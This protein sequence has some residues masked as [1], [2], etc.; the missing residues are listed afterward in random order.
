MDTKQSM[1]VT[2]TGVAIS[3][4][5]VV[6]LGFLFFG[7][8]LFTPFTPEPAAALPVFGTENQSLMITDTVVG[9]GA[10]ATAGT[11]VSLHYVGQLENGQVFD[12]S[13][14]HGGPFTFVLGSGMVIAGWEQGILGMKVGGKRRL[15]IPP[16]L[17]Y[18]SQ[19]VG[20]IPA[21]ATLIFDVEL[22]NVT[23][24]R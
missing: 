21:N 18:G 23:P 7:A 4:A 16:E 9:T 11:E 12:A 2:P 20:P 24:A 15:V 1:T 14:N 8:S 3:L 19:A 17:G 13:A 22:V 10:E 5:V 6:A